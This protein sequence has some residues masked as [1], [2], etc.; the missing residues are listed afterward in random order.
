[1]IDRFFEWIFEE[2]PFIFSLMIFVLMIIV[3]KVLLDLAIL[4]WLS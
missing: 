1:M 3:A 4:W 2:H